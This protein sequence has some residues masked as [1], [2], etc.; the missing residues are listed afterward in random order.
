MEE[1]TLSDSIYEVIIALIPKPDKDTK[2]KEKK[3]INQLLL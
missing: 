2:R 3:A 1:E